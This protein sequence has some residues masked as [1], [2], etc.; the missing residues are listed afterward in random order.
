MGVAAN[1]SHALCVQHPPASNPRY[2]PQFDI[3]YDIICN[4]SMMSSSACGACVRKDMHSECTNTC[5][6]Y[7]DG[8]Q[9]VLF[10]HCIPHTF[11]YMQRRYE[12]NGHIREE[13]A[14]L[15]KILV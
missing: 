12:I 10:V 5:M 4:R 11:F 2:A 7:S 9:R 8:I 15:V 13:I 1:F 6:V 14:E 3:F